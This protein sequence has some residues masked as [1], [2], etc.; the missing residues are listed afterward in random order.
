[1]SSAIDVYVS[2]SREDRERVQQIVAGLEGKGL[3]C[4][5]DFEARTLTAISWRNQIRDI[6]NSVRCVLVIWSRHSVTDDWVLEEAEIAKQRGLLLPILLED[7]RP[8]LDFAVIHSLDFS[9]WADDTGDRRFLSLLDAI[10]QTISLSSDGVEM[11]DVSQSKRSQV[12]RQD[13]FTDDTEIETDDP[14]EKPG[15]KAGK[16]STPEAEGSPKGQWSKAFQRLQVVKWLR[17]TGLA[18]VGLLCIYGSITLARLGLY[19]MDSPQTD[20]L[21]QP[22]LSNPGQGPEMVLIEGGS[23]AMGS[24]VSSDEQPVH[25]VTVQDFAI[26]RCEVTFEEYER[27][28]EATGRELPSDDGWGRG[29]RP[30]IDVSWDDARAYAA[31][32]SQQTGKRYRLPSEAE[33]EYAARAGSLTAYPWGN[34]ASHEQ[35]NYGTDECCDGKKEGRDQWEFTAPVGQFPANAFGLHDMHGNVDEW[36]EDCWHDNYSGAPQDGSA[37]LEADGGSCE[38]RVVR[39]GSWVDYPWWLRSAFRFRDVS[40]YRITYLGFRLVQ[41]LPQ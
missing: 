24:N 26:G 19:A 39:G 33:W 7:V 22:C 32:L 31:W 28:A 8:P 40:T 2:Y 30:V 12:N 41:D 34:K 1:M 5:V 38:R 35:A 4:F 21:P 9:N 27:F 11:S 25:Q 20:K 15:S 3:N 14:H 37:W 36:V 23:F 6:L 17:L 29:N 13:D 16:P 10:R 18:G